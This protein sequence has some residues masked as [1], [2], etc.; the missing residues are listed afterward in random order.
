MKSVQIHL[1]IYL[2]FIFLVVSFNTMIQH[3]QKKPTVWKVDVSRNGG[4]TLET[5]YRHRHLDGWD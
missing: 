4:S 3:I 1:F 5:R 2:L